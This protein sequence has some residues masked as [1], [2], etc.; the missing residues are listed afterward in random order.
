MP[1]PPPHCYNHHHRHDSPLPSLWLGFPFL[2]PN[3]SI[4]LVCSLMLLFCWMKEY[5]F[6]RSL[7][8]FVPLRLWCLYIWLFLGFI[9]VFFLVCDSFFSRELLLPLTTHRFHFLRFSFYYTKIPPWVLPTWNW[10]KNTEN[11]FNSEFFH[12][13]PAR[14]LFHITFFQACNLQSVWLVA[15]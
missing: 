4:S 1:P 12:H 5:N 7:S 2:L 6:V 15:W 9:V 10:W 13:P 3:F 11:L 14:S 8:H